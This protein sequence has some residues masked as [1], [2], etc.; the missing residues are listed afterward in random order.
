MCSDQIKKPR[1]GTCLHSLDLCSDY[2]CFHNDDDLGLVDAAFSNCALAA[3]IEPRH[4][5]RVWLLLSIMRG[6]QRPVRPSG[7]SANG[8]SRS[9]TD[10]APSGASPC[11]CVCHVFSGG[12][13]CAPFTSH[14]WDQL[15]LG[16]FCW[17]PS[18][19]HPSFP[20]MW[21]VRIVDNR[22]TRYF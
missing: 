3:C 1:T 6:L 16:V 20:G 5:A 9:V 7:D 11:G 21:L 12:S 2:C 22:S 8:H 14:G 13:V 17:C 4:V 19:R 10:D 18:G 15:W